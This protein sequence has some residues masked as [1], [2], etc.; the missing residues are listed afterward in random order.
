M[1]INEKI[2]EKLADFEA[3]TGVVPLAIYLGIEEIF[4]LKEWM[5]TTFGGTFDIDD[6]E[7]YGIKIYVVMRMNY[8]G[9][10]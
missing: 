9:V 6:P 3:T 10:G 8:L 1:R 5:H 4:L 2:L 7:L